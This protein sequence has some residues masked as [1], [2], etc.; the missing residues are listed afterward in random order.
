[1]PRWPTKEKESPPPF[2]L[3]EHINLGDTVDTYLGVEIRS[4]HYAY[5]PGGVREAVVAMLPERPTLCNDEATA[6]EVIRHRM[7][8]KRRK[9]NASNQGVAGETPVP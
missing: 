7:G 5:A 6:V 2:N 1:M 3:L 8:K 4:C 9:K